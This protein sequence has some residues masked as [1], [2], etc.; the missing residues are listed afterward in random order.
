[1][2]KG[3]LKEISE[4]LGN[5]RKL[6]FDFDGVVMSVTG[7]YW[8]SVHETLNF[9]FS[10]LLGFGRSLSLISNDE[11]KK[12]KD[13]G[14]Y[15]DDWKITRDLTLYYLSALS[16]NLAEGRRLSSLLN[17][18][19]ALKNP[20]ELA[21]K[22]KDLGEY[23]ANQGSTAGALA[24]AKAGLKSFLKALT[25]GKS[26][27]GG[28]TEVFPN[29]PSWT[30]DRLE[31]LVWAGGDLIKKIFEEF[32][33]GREL[34][35]RFYG[36]EALFNLGDG[37]IDNEKPLIS[38][39]TLE[40]LRPKFGK[41]HIYSERPRDSAIY[42]LNKHG[43]AGY[44]D[45]NLSYFM[46]DLLKVGEELGSPEGAGK[47]NPTPFLRLLRKIGVEPSAALYVGDNASD[48]ILVER[49]RSEHSA[50]V[51]FV[52]VANGG[53]KGADAAL[54]NVNELPALLQGGEVG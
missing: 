16:S 37:F 44:F 29:L 43:L 25:E 26:A 42:A 12:F 6:I 39:Q 11:I 46:E 38:K 3:R 36:E 47:P 33:L 13:T 50:N 41:I 22:L 7:S 19:S 48:L 4:A 1:M 52:I 14:M 54:K 23:F 34:Y 31:K 15:N 40:A 10:K 21:V 18:L 5:V 53:F 30:V 51:R 24:A 8:R 9:Y 27:I 28:S 17:G 20:A 45:L 2:S 49:L 32:Y 35:E